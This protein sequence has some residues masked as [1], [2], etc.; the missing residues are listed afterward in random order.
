MVRDLHAKSIK[1]KIYYTIREL[2]NYAPELWVLRSLGGEVIAD[3]AGGGAPWLREQL[4]DG[5]SPA[6][7]SALPEGEIDAAV[8]TQGLSR[9]CNFYV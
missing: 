4:V 1:T 8:L 3:G 6:W 9:W 7:V 2:T 5:Y